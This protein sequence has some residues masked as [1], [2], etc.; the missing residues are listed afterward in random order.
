[1]VIAFTT[2]A[3]TGKK[4]SP[5]ISRWSGRPWPPRPASFPWDWLDSVRCRLLVTVGIL[6]TET[7]GDFIPAGGEAPEQHGPD[8]R[9][10]EV[11]EPA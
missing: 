9:H 5:I 7:S 8:Q 3:L 10:P 2:E 4:D 6:A 1:M 11:G